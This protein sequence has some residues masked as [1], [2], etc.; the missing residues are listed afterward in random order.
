MFE[1][2]EWCGSGV[3]SLMTM[4]GVPSEIGRVPNVLGDFLVEATSL[5][6]SLASGLEAWDSRRTVL[7][8]SGH[9]FYGEAWFYQSKE[10]RVSLLSRL[11][12]LLA[13]VTWKTVL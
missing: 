9:R 12:I 7:D 5:V 4:L 11:G 13:V 2:M 1:C 8:P 10:N 6:I 3:A